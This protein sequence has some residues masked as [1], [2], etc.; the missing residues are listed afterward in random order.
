MPGLN[1]KS[2][3]D[4]SNFK[5][6]DAVDIAWE[7]LRR[8]HSYQ[9]DYGNLIRGARSDEDVVAFR[10]KWGLSFRS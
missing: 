9:A 5:T 2:E 4:Y 3:E 7:W 8:D 1:W 6:A 10:T